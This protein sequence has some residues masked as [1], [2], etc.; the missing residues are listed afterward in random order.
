MGPGNSGLRADHA[1]FNTLPDE[2]SLVVGFMM[3]DDNF[4][5][6]KKFCDQHT[7]IAPLMGEA[8]ARFNPIRVY[9]RWKSL[10]IEV[11]NGELA[12]SK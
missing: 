3:D 1:G 6:V 10:N 4:R 8:Q 12:R 2:Q 11:R 9:Y 5:L 7:K